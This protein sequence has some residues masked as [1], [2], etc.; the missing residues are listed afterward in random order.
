MF[1]EHILRDGYSHVFLSLFP[2][3]PHRFLPSCLFS[4]K[5]LPSTYMFLARH[6]QVLV[7]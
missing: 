4:T 1:I 3:L 2:S 7:M 5:H 6:S